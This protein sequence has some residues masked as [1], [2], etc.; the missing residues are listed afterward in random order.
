MKARILWLVE[1]DRDTSFFH[2][3]ALVRRRCNRILCMKD[4][5]GNWLDGDKE[6]A[7]FIRKGFST[8][9]TT[10]IICAPLADWIPPFWQTFLKE[11]EARHLD[12]AVSNEEIT[13]GL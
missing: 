8:L 13:A 2:T 11:E 3:S 6:I 10:G 4:S 12:R 1:G 9:L 5:M 7:D